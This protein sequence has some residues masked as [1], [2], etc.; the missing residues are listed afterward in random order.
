MLLEQVNRNLEAYAAKLK[1]KAMSEKKE[2]RRKAPEDGGFK[3]IGV[4]VDAETYGKLVSLS[5]D[6][7]IPSLKEAALVAIKR[8]ILTTRLAR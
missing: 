1:E 7:K 3:T 4:R 6:E 5:E 2:G 8:G